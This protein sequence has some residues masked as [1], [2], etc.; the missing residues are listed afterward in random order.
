MNE[1]MYWELF[2]RNIGIVTEQEQQKLAK[3]SVRVGG[4]G[5]VGGML[6]Y[7]FA[8]SGVGEIW[9]TDPEKFDRSNCNRQFGANSGTIGKY[10]SEVVGDELLRINPGLELKI[11]YGIDGSNVDEFARGADFI[12]DSIEIFYMR[13]KV[14]LYDTARKYNVPV[15]F[16]PA[17]GFGAALFLFDPR[18]M[19]FEEFFE[20][21]SDPEEL[22]DWMYPIHKI[23]PGTQPYVPKEVW[24]KVAQKEMDAP[25]SIVGV[26]CSAAMSASA[27]LEHILGKAE[28]VYAPRVSHLDLFEKRYNIIE[29]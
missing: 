29:Y 12:S 13:E 23:K 21:P 11:G 15:S 27:A 19:T 17:L 16:A 28:P 20:V 22:R 8:R 5:G 26:A 4:A 1:D 25:T 24:L 10:K 18:G 9:I 7:F 3:S 6:A 14:M 2:K